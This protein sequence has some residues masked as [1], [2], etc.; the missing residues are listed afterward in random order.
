MFN[1]IS[2]DNIKEYKKIIKNIY[3][4]IHNYKI[5]LINTLKLKHK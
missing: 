5:K 2:K 4:L 1:I 3:L